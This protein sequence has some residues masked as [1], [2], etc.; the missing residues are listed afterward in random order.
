MDRHG[1]ETALLSLSSPGV[2]FG[3]ATAARRLA[4]EVNEYAAGLARDH[5]GRFGSFA[6]LPLPDVD[7]ALD[8]IAYALDDLGAHGVVLLSNLDGMYLGDARLEPV[9][10]E[11]SR[12]NAVVV[13]HPTSPPGWKQTALGRPRAMLEYLFDTTRSVADLL[14]TGV[15]DRHRGLQVV[16]PHCGG[17]LPV[18]ADRIDEFTKLFLPAHQSAAADPLEQLRGCY[19]DLA[20]TAFPRQAR[21]LLELVDLDRLLFGSDYCWTPP[22]VTDAHVGAIDAAETPLAG[23]TWRSLTTANAQRLFPRLAP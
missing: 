10:A 3:D 5:P 12:R 7:G 6:A 19:Y 16:I 2:Y 11:L 8:E 13:L 23:L 1:I 18:L 14:V 22:P 9:F 15:L 4:R 17:A 21:A 20:G